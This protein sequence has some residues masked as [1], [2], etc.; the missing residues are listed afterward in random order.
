MSANA[1]VL[2][3]LIKVRLN[4]GYDDAHIIEQF[5]KTYGYDRNEIVQILERNK[6]KVEPKPVEIKQVV[7]DTE[8]QKEMLIQFENTYF[9]VET[10]KTSPKIETSEVEEGFELVN[11]D[12]GFI[13]T[14]PQ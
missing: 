10:P 5:V 6:P 9:K 4:K 1:D 13:K 8:I 7:E 2:E 3:Q 14:N 11:K 12:K